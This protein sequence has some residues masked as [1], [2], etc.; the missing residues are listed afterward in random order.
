MIALKAGKTIDETINEIISI[1]NFNYLTIQRIIEPTDS[2]AKDFNTGK[3]SAI[4]IK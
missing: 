4:Y 1:K 2:S 3:K